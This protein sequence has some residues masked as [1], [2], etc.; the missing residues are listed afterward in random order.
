MAKAS[1]SGLPTNV[2]MKAVNLNLQSEEDGR[3]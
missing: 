1:G 2:M 3:Y